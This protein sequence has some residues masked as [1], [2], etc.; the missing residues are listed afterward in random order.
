MLYAHSVSES[1]K[2]I[3]YSSITNQTVISSS[4]EGSVKDYG[5]IN[6][7]EMWYYC[8]GDVYDN[9]LTYNCAVV[10]LCNAMR[11]IRTEGFTK[12]SSNFVTL[13]NDLWKLSAAT[14]SHGTFF[15]SAASGA[16]DYLHERGYTAAYN[17]YWLS[18]YSD[19][20]RDINDGLCCTLSFAASSTGH[21]VFVPGYL[22][23]SSYQYLCVIDGWDSRYTRYLNYNGFNYTRKNG[24]CLIA[25]L[26]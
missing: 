22:E 2:Q 21:A 6:D 24:W 10:G 25:S 19:F 16:V 7:N 9:G 12:I 18:L 8:S 15:E 4:Y 26:S 20:K 23:T 1:E 14:S 3:T 11:Y 13:Y 5:R 17:L